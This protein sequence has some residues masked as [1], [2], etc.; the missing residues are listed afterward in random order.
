MDKRLLPY[1]FVWGVSLVAVYAAVL[2]FFFS[3]IPT[4]IPLWGFVLNALLAA[5]YTH[6]ERPELPKDEDFQDGFRLVHWHISFWLLVVVF[7]MLSL[8]DLSSVPSSDRGLRT[9]AD[10]ALFTCLA[11]LTGWV[12][13]RIPYYSRLERRVVGK[14]EF[15]EVACILILVLLLG[16]CALFV[17][18]WWFLFIGPLLI[19][20]SVIAFYRLYKNYRKGKPL[21]SDRQRQYSSILSS[22]PLSYKAYRKWETLARE[23]LSPRFFFVYRL[24]FMLLIF[25][26]YAMIFFAFVATLVLLFS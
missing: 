23:T 15:I 7:T 21:V 19:F 22:V 4:I 8:D 5:A 1:G 10:V 9:Q 13:V 16:V 14:A 2:T 24:Q 20:V 6:H 25:S 12:F 3:H 11:V 26:I 17:D 18:S